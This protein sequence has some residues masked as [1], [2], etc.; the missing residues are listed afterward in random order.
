MSEDKKPAPKATKKPSPK[1]SMTAEQAKELGL[2]PF[3]YGGK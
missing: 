2:D 1:V 3:P